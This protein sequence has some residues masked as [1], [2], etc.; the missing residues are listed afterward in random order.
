MHVI[1]ERCA[2]NGNGIRSQE[3]IGGRA[4]KLEQLR[5]EARSKGREWL[6][7]ALDDVKW[8]EVRE[9]ARAAGLRVR[10]EDN[11]AWMPVGELREALLEHLAP[12]RSLASQEF[13]G[14]FSREPLSEGFFE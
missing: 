3:G 5:L 6:G 11:V 8:N 12:E 4:A 7:S 9:L 10:R 14:Y 13:A 2:R 1:V